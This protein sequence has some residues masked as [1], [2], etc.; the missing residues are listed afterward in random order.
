VGRENPA[1]V[2]FAWIPS[3]KKARTA[4]LQDFGPVFSSERNNHHPKS[5]R[6]ES[7]TIIVAV[8]PKYPQKNKRML[9][10]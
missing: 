6:C 8:N 4:F 9:L 10:C 3:K 7:D 5:A 2:R 1:K